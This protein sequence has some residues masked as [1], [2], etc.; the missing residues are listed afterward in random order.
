MDTSRTPQGPRPH[1]PI[2]TGMSGT[3]VLHSIT[4][5]KLTLYLGVWAVYLVVFNEL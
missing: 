3:G 4:I 5:I 2:T 1:M